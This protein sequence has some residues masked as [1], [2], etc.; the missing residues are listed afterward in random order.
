MSRLQR[1]EGGGGVTTTRLK[2]QIG[3]SSLFCGEEKVEEGQFSRSDSQL[4]Q[5]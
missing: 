3:E 2:V 1:K 5:L 4:W